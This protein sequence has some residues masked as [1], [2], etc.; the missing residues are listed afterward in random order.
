MR[1][2]SVWTIAMGMPIRNTNARK[3]AMT[4]PLA[5]HLNTAGRHLTIVRC[6]QKKET[7][8]MLQAFS[9][10]IWLGLTA[11]LSNV[12]IMGT[13]VDVICKRPGHALET[14]HS[15][16]ASQPLLRRALLR[17]LLSGVVANADGAARNVSSRATRI[18]ATGTVIAGYTSSVHVGIVK[19]TTAWN[20]VSSM[21]CAMAYGKY[22]GMVVRLM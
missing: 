21:K 17:V 19:M 3:C 18:F 14:M 1:P 5:N 8:L 4:C 22:K 20:N 9:H 2:R 16:V 13:L 11:Q 6:T 12:T 7:S 15:K 10:V